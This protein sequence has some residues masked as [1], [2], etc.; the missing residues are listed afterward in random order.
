MN[1][2]LLK[3]KNK[4]FDTFFSYRKVQK[5]K[6]YRTI[7]PVP[8]KLNYI[9]F[10]V[11]GKKKYEVKGKEIIKVKKVLK[12]RKVIK[13]QKER[14]IMSFVEKKFVLEEYYLSDYK[15]RVKLLDKKK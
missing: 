2:Q 13:Y 7:K 5:K 8:L 14:K 3:L 11:K 15:E 9:K 1:L 10:K 4:K 12:K 6:Y